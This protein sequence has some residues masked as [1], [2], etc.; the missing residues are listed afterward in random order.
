MVK[1]YRACSEEVYALSRE[2]FPFPSELKK[3]YLSGEIEMWKQNAGK[4]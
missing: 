3:V 2:I 4:Y 1:Y